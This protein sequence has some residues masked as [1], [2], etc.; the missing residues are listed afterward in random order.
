MPKSRRIT[1]PNALKNPGMPST[2]LSGGSSF[3]PVDDDDD[4]EKFL[5]LVE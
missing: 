5:V 1:F 3:L 2:G 4:D